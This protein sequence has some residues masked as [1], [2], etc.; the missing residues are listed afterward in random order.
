MASNQ[1]SAIYYLALKP[2]VP[3]FKCRH[4]TTPVNANYITVVPLA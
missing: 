3:I 4:V 1:I 2:S